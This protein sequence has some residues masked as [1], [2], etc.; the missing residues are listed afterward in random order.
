MAF[1]P[2]SLKRPR[3]LG[4]LHTDLG[5][6]KRIIWVPIFSIS[7]D[8]ANSMII[9]P[10]LPKSFLTTAYLPYPTLSRIRVGTDM[11]LPI[12]GTRL[13]NRKE[14]MA[15]C[16][17]VGR[18]IPSDCRGAA[19]QSCGPTAPQWPFSLGHLHLRGG[20]KK[21]AR[22]F[23]LLPWSSSFA[24]MYV[25]NYSIPSL[26]SSKDLL[27]HCWRKQRSRAACTETYLG[28]SLK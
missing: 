5:V 15:P 20:G 19:G 25:K 23:A 16:L 28:A 14:N 17:C 21:L 13:L 18:V 10:L 2:D 9:K 6:T 12:S 8:Q 26:K 22:T 3:S 4:P 27:R 11:S 7:E 1:I 24:G